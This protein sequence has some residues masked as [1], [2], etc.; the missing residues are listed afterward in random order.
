VFLSVFQK[1]VVHTEI[2]ETAKIILRSS[3]R[4]ETGHNKGLNH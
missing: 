1:F 2:F 3:L 4:V